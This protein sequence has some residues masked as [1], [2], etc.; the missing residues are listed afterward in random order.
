[1]RLDLGEDEQFFQETVR[2]FVETEMPITE[3]TFGV[4]YEGLRPK[5]AVH[6]LLSREA[7]PE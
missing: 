5:T 4:L 7:K 2:R 6:N 3:Q 1:M